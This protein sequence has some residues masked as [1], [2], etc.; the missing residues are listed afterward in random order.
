M[1]NGV[2]RMSEKR[3]GTGR[4]V[5]ASGQAKVGAE[6]GDTRVSA[7]VGNV[8]GQAPGAVR[9]KL[10]RRAGNTSIATTKSRC[11]NTVAAENAVTAEMPAMGKTI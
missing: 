2:T 1:M 6:R 8:L 11:T 10:R 7:Q 4:S 5:K 9:T 3:G